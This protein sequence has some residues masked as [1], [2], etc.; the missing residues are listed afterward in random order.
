M[1]PT[2]NAATA[3]EQL[4]RLLLVLPSLA[5]DRV[6]SLNDVA[7]KVD[8]D[9]ATV[10]R[11]LVSLVNRSGDEPGGFT[12]GIALLLG[13]DTV[14]LQTPAGH[15]RRPMALTRTELQAIE[16]GLAMLTQ[17]LPPD[18][19]EVLRG[20]RERLQQA[21]A[22]LPM[23]ESPRGQTH[24][25][26]LGHETS[27]AQQVRRDLQECIRARRVATIGYR[28]ATQASDDRRRVYPLGIVWSRG[29]WYLVAWCER[30][31]G[32]R[33]FRLD[34]ISASRCEAERFK[35]IDGFALD[36]V[37]RDGRVLVGDE[38]AP[39]RVRYGPRIARWIAER[40]SAVIEADGSVV[41]EH[42]AITEDW[43]VRH[44]LR[45]GPDAEILEPA[46]LREAVVRRL[47][48]LGA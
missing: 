31:D 30:S 28:S 9:A 20:A 26:T 41:V 33:V 4:R 36:D 34:R 2:P 40:E 5:D 42:E 21:L 45:Y 39:M 24:H 14:Q 11:D 17:E 38:G 35:S 12:E 29:L 37:L 18:E 43:A 46:A 8:S 19:R 16:L 6:H 27:A 1:S 7:R 48:A 25:A 22:R 13:P 10:R 32:L 15:F 3:A 47:A 44:V 23:S